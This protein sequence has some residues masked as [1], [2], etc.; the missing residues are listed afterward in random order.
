[1]NCFDFFTHNFN[2]IL[3]ISND[4]YKTNFLNK[5][6]FLNKKYY[7]LCFMTQKR[8]KYGV[9]KKSDRIYKGKVYDSKL[10]ML[11]RKRLDLLTKSVKLSERVTDIKEQVPY[12]IVINGKK[13]CKYILDFQVTYGDGRV[14]YVD[15]KGI[16][17]SIYRLKKKLVEA[18]FPIKIKEVKKGQFL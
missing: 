5:T 12:E 10:E 2:L 14:E 16:L 3:I 18:S 17:T 4:K 13:I 15:V 1:M 6:K 8:S 11:Y 9:A 7:Y